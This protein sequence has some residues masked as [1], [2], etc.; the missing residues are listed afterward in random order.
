MYSTDD[1]H[2]YST[3]N[4]NYDDTCMYTFEHAYKLCSTDKSASWSKFHDPVTYP[5]LSK[6]M[7]S[8]LEAPGATWMCSKFNVK[9]T[10]MFRFHIFSRKYFVSYHEHFPMAKTIQTHGFRVN[11][12]KTAVATNTHRGQ[13][14]VMLKYRDGTFQYSHS[15]EVYTVAEKCGSS[16]IIRFIRSELCE[17]LLD[18]NVLLITWYSSQM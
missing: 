18:R 6:S 8:D 12:T 15:F 5:V 13:W 2:S 3:L 14:K 4:Y 7:V 10:W 1:V 9:S 11:Q 16:I 17:Q